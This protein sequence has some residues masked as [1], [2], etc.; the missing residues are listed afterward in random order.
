MFFSEDNLR[1]YTPY[2]NILLND[3]EKAPS[4]ICNSLN[5]CVLE[6]GSENVKF[7]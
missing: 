7:E 4:M 5:K 6:E 3:I 2:K 1:V